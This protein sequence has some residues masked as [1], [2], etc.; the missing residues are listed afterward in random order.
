MVE[1]EINRVHGD[2]GFEARY[3]AGHVVRMDNKV[4]DGGDNFGA[5]PMGLLLMGLGGCSGVDVISI[6]KKGRQRVDGLRIR[7]GGVREKDAVPAVWV[8]AKVLYELT[9]DI[10]PVKARRA[11]E[12]S[13]APAARSPGT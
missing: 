5:S 10:D 2:Y 11:C 6:L 7:I 1:I 13:D 8:G 4:D 3:A 12:L 9:G